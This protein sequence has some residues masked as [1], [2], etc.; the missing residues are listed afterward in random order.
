M[1]RDPS[2]GGEADSRANQT[3]AVGIW[4]KM[5]VPRYFEWN[6]LVAKARNPKPEI[7]K[8]SEGRSPKEASSSHRS[9][10]SDSSH[11][12]EPASQRPT[13]SDFGF[14]ISGFGLRIFLTPIPLKTAKNHDYSAGGAVVKHMRATPGITSS[15]PVCPR[16]RR[17]G[18]LR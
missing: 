8:K 10:S 7:R 6:K 17:R 11:S 5:M 15:P 13:G 2:A 9:P 3:C 1:L 12:L 4:R 18:K 14:R 16:L